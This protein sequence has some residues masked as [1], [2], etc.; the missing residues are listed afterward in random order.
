MGC[1]A[2]GSPPAPLPGSANLRCTGCGLVVRPAPR[3]SRI[4]RS[5]RFPAPGVLGPVE[6][7]THT[8]AQLEQAAAIASEAARRRAADAASRSPV[9]IEPVEES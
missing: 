4:V 8:K 5:P 1:P 3:A 7:H 6:T 9:P 2:C